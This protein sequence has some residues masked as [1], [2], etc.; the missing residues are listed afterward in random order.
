M[1]IRESRES[2]LMG[3]KLDILKLELSLDVNLIFYNYIYITF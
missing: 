1:Y 3:S 2:Q